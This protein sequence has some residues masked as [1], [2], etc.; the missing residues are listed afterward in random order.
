M[1]R[2]LTSIAIITAMLATSCGGGKDSPESI[3]QKWCDLDK[4]VNEATSEEEEEAAREKREA[5]EE[6]MTKKYGEDEAFME[7]IGKATEACEDDGY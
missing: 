1:S 3:A 7:K 2:I 4:A 6:E 5:Y